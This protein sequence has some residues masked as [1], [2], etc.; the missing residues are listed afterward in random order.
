MRQCH[1]TQTLIKLCYQP[2]RRGGNFEFDPSKDKTS[3]FG[4]SQVKS[5]VE[6]LEEKLRIIENLGFSGS[7]N[8]DSLT[9]FPRLSCLKSLSR[10]SF[11]N[12]MVPVILVPTCACFVERWHPMEIINLCLAKSS[13]IDWLV[14][15]PHGLRVERA[16]SLRE[17]SYAFLDFN[18]F[19]IEIALDRIDLQRMEKKSEESFQEY[20]QRWREKATQVQTPP[21]WL[22]KRWSNGSL[23]TLSHLTMRIWSMFK[24]P[25]LPIWYPRGACGWR[26]HK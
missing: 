18:R 13:R 23:I 19:I 21:T 2:A 7:V 12:M 16:L 1:L 4:F 8:F 25:T 11:W 17:M 10:R 14:L 5:L 26:Y 22:K 15:Q 20:A 9:S 24:Y 6:T 3:E